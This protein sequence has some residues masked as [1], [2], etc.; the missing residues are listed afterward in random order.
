LAVLHRAVPVPVPVIVVALL[1]VALA[2]WSLAGGGPFPIRMFTGP[3]PAPTRTEAPTSTPSPTLTIELLAPAYVTGT[4]IST[5]LAPTLAPPAVGLAPAL[6]GAV[7]QVMT[8]TD[9]ERATGAGTF[10]LDVT[11]GWGGLQFLAGDLRLEA[12]PGT[13]EGECTGA[14]WSG[15]TPHYDGFAGAAVSCW[16]N[17]GGPYDGMT[18]YL[19]YRFA[20][21]ES[22]DEVVGTI[23]PAEPPSP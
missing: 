21:W 11:A 5:Q 13:W 20:G 2:G 9:D 22:P 16:L 8:T 4:G 14:G 23:L 10:Q 3:A 19:N 18:F 12:G 6:A 15:I 17:G 7:L 1:I